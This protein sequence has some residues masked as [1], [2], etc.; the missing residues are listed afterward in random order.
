M[1]ALAKLC[2]TL[3]YLVSGSDAVRSERTNDLASYGIN[4][5]VGA[6]KTRRDLRVADV[7]VYTDAISGDH[8]EFVQAKLLKKTMLSRA[9]LLRVVCENFSNVISVAGSHGKTTCTA[10]TAHVLRGLNVPFTAHI[11]GED[12]EFGN[13][14]YTGKEYLVTEA[15]EY[16]KNIRK[17]RSNRAI[18][19]NIDKDHMECY[20]NLEDLRE[21]FREYCA[22]A[23]NAFVCADDVQCLRLGDYVTFGITSPLA[24]YRAVDIRANG[25]K[26]SFT[27]EEY[28]KATCR[29]R[30]NAIGK[31]A[32]YNAL[33]SYSAVRSYGFDGGEIIKGL[34]TFQ[35]VR[36]RFE[37][38][39]VFRGASFVC[40]YAHHPRE[41][42]STLQTARGIC[43][44]KLFV[45]F[46]P[47]T[48]SRTKLLMEEFVSALSG[49]DEL[50]VYKTFPAREPYDAEGSA[51][52][53]SKRIGSLYAENA[54]V[55]KTWLKMTVREGDLVLFLGAGDVYYVAQY[56]LR[57]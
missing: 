31:S 22:Q 38:V 55:L 24:D 45:V 57:D 23:R 4:V 44:G 34:T 10:M 6:D 28:G 17:I 43:K 7:L 42:V 36:R 26:Y 48:Y 39:G 13:F 50:M 2:A 3:G 33:A 19:L 56:L 1:S 29:V 18:V 20:H 53:L 16:K 25:E 15:C 49:V 12:A 32:I 5:Y 8:E 35:A 11:G 14:H 9:D 47:H 27:I 51:E 46:Q 40:D 41:I 54:Y 30:L 52:R 21:T 37:K